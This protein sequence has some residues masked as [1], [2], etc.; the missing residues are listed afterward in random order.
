MP[1]VIIEHLKNIIGHENTPVQVVV[2]VHHSTAYHNTTPFLATVGFGKRRNALQ[3]VKGARNNKEEN[4]YRGPMS[5]SGSASSGSSSQNQT[6]RLKCLV[7]GAAGAG[8][9][10]LLRRYFHNKFD[11]TRT[12]TVGCDFYTQ[13]VTSTTTIPTA[14]SN[15]TTTTTTSAIP[16]T[17]TRPNS[18]TTSLR[19][20]RRTNHG[21]AATVGDSIHDS[22]ENVHYH[23]HQHIMEGTGSTHPAVISVSLQMWDTPGRER[24]VRAGERR[25]SLA[26]TTALGPDLFRK[27]DA[28]LLV[29]DMTSS[30]SFTQLLKAYADVMQFQRQLGPQSLPILIVANKLDL[31]HRQQEPQSNIPFGPQHRDVMGL[32]GK[33]EGNDF[34]YEYQVSSLEGISPSNHGTPTTRTQT[35]NQKNRDSSSRR[36][37]ISS[38][39]VCRDNWTDDWSYL[40]SLLD[41]EDLSH[42]DRDLVVLWCMRNGLTHCEVSAATGEG[43]SEA[44]ETLLRLALSNNAAPRVQLLNVPK[45]TRQQQPQPFLDLHQRYAPKHERC[46]VCLL[47]PLENCL[48][49]NSDAND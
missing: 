24:V 12:P 23:Q 26:Y 11:P 32:Q 44:M 1:T 37:E 14:S 46:C 9:T 49:K 15:A 47:R 20:G 31:L 33:F 6:I 7:L 45:P 41:T 25:Q 17:P 4:T 10:S 18:T 39:L 21:T 43:V 29:Y 3:G 13:R 5:H 36:M 40:A 30:T 48:P 2:Y 42:P 19:R 34:R 35:K 16:S 22:D 28:I 27:A 8:K 38:Y